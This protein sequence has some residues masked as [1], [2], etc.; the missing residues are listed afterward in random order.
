[1]TFTQSDS[2]RTMGNGYELGRHLLH[3]GSEVLA[4]LPRAVVPH[5][6]GCSGWVALW[7]LIWWEA[8][9]PGQGWGWMLLKVPSNL[10]Y[11]LI[12]A[13][14]VYLTSRPRFVLFMMT[15]GWA[16]AM[17]IRVTATHRLLV[18]RLVMGSSLWGSLRTELNCCTATLCCYAFTDTVTSAGWNFAL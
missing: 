11:P 17:W 10:S 2:D 1:M 5:P 9:N 12:I 4:V 14:F 8:P 13:E 18:H 16:Y 7:A 6:W 3:R 15:N